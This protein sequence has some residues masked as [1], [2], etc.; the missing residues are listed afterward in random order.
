MLRSGPGFQCRPDLAQEKGGEDEGNVV[1]KMLEILVFHGCA[2]W[3][4]CWIS[5]IWH[6]PVVIGE[7][8][9]SSEPCAP[10][11]SLQWSGR[12]CNSAEHWEMLLEPSQTEQQVTAPSPPQDVTAMTSWTCFPCS[13]SAPEHLDF[14]CLSRLRVLWICHSSSKSHLCC[15]LSLMDL[16]D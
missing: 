5:Q 6:F 12:V 16:W 10:R 1:A 2:V 11:G 4:R 8:S 14:Y 7:F 15:E 13:P 3:G 9:V